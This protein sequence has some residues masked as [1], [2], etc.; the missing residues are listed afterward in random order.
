MKIKLFTSL[1]IMLSIAAAGQPRVSIVPRPKIME[2]K[3]HHFELD[4]GV[5]IALSTAQPELIKLASYTRGQLKN[6]FGVKIASFNPKH[7]AQ[8]QIIFS[9]E[10]SLK[11]LGNEGYTLTVSPREVKISAKGS[12]GIFYG[13]QTLLQ[14]I[15]FGKK[16][17]IPCL[18]IKDKPRFGWR[19]MMLD[20]SRHF[21][22]V[23]EIKTFL[24]IM[25]TYKMNVFHW[26]LTDSQGWRLEIKKYP[27]LTSVGAWRMENPKAVF[28]QKDSLLKGKEEKYGGFYTQEQ[29]KE[30]VAYAKDRN[31]TVI[32]EIELP[33][34]SQAALAAYPEFSCRQ[35]PQEVPGALGIQENTTSNYCPGNDSTFT[36]LE[37]VLTEVMEIFPSKYI[38]IGGDE[39]NKTEWKNDPKCQALIKAKGLKNE[40]GLQ[41]YFIHRIASFLTRHG[42]TIIG[43]DETLQGGLAPGAVVQ[44]WRGIKGGIKA[45]NLHHGV[46]MSPANPLYFNRYQGDSATEPLAAKWSINTLEKVYNFDCVPSALDAVSAKYIMGGEG[47]IWT[48]FF[49]TNDYIQYMLLPRLLALSELTW[50]TPENKNWESFLDRLPYQFKLFD[51][52]KWNYDRKDINF[53]VGN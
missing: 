8:R 26:H 50:S 28:F 17:E 51:Q 18:Y 11:E 6:R 34:H 37:D 22:T 4:K 1:F 14:T 7:H 21:F 9:L 23:Q 25:A 29:A 53:E 16:S 13:I 49:K 31:I 24:D 36:F 12:K 41:S 5:A 45:A 32:P 48:E 30:I 46:I 52:K 10:P 39:V 19:G 3:S 42:K 27:K 44:S 2:I 20:V 15:S 40:E 35:Q 38:H 43:W 47:A 33:G